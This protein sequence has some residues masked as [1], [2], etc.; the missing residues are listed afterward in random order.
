MS[1]VETIRRARALLEQEG[2][3]SLRVLK[4][5]FTLDDEALAELVEELVEVQQVAVRQGQVL[6]WGGAPPT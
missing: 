2:R 5:E 6:A 4:R 3:I 1:V